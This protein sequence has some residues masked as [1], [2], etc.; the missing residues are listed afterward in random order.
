MDILVIPLLL[1]L[2]KKF[3]RNWGKK[4][5]A[6]L[7]LKRGKYLLH[8]FSQSEPD[9]MHKIV[10]NIPNNIPI[11]L[12]ETRLKLVWPQSLPSISIEQSHAD[13]L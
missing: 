3:G 9:L 11:Y 7:P 2:H 4:S 1:M 5:M 10:Q 6:F 8:L 13:L 12:I